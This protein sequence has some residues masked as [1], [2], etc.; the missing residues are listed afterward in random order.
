MDARDILKNAMKALG[1]SDF[2]SWT[3]DRV[4]VGRVGFGSVTT[5][6]REDTLDFIDTLKFVIKSTK[7]ERHRALNMYPSLTAE[8]SRPS[9]KLSDAIADHL[10]DLGRRRLAPGTIKSTTHTMSLLKSVCGDIPV[11]EI[12]GSHIRAFWDAVRW[13]PR[14]ARS[15]KEFR[16]LTDLQ[17]VAEGKRIRVPEASAHTFNCHQQRLTVFFKALIEA[18]LIVNSPTN[19]IDHLI[20]TSTEPATGRAF[21]DTELRDMFEH[22]TFIAWAKHHP[23]RWWGSMLGLYSGARVNEVAQLKLDDIRQVEGVWCVFFR[24]TTDVRNTDDPTAPIS[25]QRIKC[26]SSIRFIPIAEPLLDAG[27]LDYVEDMRATKH[28]RLFPHLP[29]GK[30]KEGLPNGCGYGLQLGKQFGKYALGFAQE[31]K[32]AFHA[33]RHTLSTHLAEVGVDLS[34]IAQITGHAMARKVPALEN[35]YVHI[36]ESRKLSDKMEALALFKPPVTLP[37]YTRGQFKRQL[38]RPSEFNP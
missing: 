3:A 33:F 12:T 1:N 13:W 16:G 20:N 6:G 10:A 37:I 14:L 35:H 18:S 34:V 36:S 19:G 17:I 27:F 31:K 21:T 15:K 28:P 2:H 32:V 38:A 30:T 22:E 26:K 4:N 24:K 29:A 7:R 25:R 8:A 5:S 23:H 9:R 11:V